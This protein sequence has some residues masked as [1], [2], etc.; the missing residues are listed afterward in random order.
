MPKHLSPE[1]VVA[2]REASRLLKQ[3]GTLSAGDGPTLEIYAETRAR[4]IAAKKDLAERGLQII[5]T[6]L[7]KNG[8]AVEREKTNPNL[9]VAE[10]CEKQLLALAKSLGLTPDTREKV[11]PPRPDPA[12]APLAPTSMAAKHPEWFDKKGKL[13]NGIKF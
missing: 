4:W 10:V 7:D 8:N 9:K 6:M 11:K 1:G 3:R 12:D 5:V 2:W 13:K